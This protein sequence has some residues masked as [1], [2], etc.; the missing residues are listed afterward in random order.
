[1]TLSVIF[2][3]QQSLHANARCHFADRVTNTI[4]IVISTAAHNSLKESRYNND[5][6][7]RK[8]SLIKTLR[9]NFTLLSVVQFKPGP[10]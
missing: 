2:L 5:I 3:L 1:M 4:L 6:D 8:Q 9:I 10:E 7:Q